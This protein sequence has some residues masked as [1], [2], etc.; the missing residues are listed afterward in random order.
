MGARDLKALS[1]NPAGPV[2]NGIFGVDIAARSG[3]KRFHK[4]ARKA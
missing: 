1:L 2:G 3:C 4:P